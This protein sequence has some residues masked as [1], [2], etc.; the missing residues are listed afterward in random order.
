MGLALA[1]ARVQHRQV[2]RF[3]ASFQELPQLGDLGCT[4]NTR[5]RARFAQPDVGGARHGRPVGGV[6]L[7]GE[8]VAQRY[9]KAW[10]RRRALHHASPGTV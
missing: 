5:K 10:E 9:R 7:V 8:G 1:V 2:Q 6:P 4:V 3:Q